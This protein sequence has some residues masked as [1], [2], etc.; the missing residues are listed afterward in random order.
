MT[1][2]GTTATTPTSTTRTA[3]ITLLPPAP[4]RTRGCR[5]TATRATTG[6]PREGCAGSG[7]GCLAQAGGLGT[8]TSAG[9]FKLIKS[10]SPPPPF[11]SKEGSCLLV[12][13]KR[14]RKGGEWCVCVCMCGSVLNRFLWA[15]VF[16]RLPRGMATSWR[17]DNTWSDGQIY[18]QG[19][20]LRGNHSH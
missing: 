15:V 14:E 1:R 6:P 5:P 11:L 13:N 2:T 8:V 12:D 19:D 17:L 4:T 3:T 9:L 7:T 10:R 16:S 20:E 18:F